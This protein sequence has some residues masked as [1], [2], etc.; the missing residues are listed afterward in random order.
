MVSGR[1]WCIWLDG[2]CSQTSLC[3][4]RSQ[5]GLHVSQE[6][7]LSCSAS[8]PERCSYVLSWLMQRHHHNKALTFEGTHWLGFVAD[9]FVVWFE[10]PCCG[11]PA[12]SCIRHL[13]RTCS[14][15]S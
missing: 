5:A 12:V 3:P 9:A 15:P 2:S 1:R 14:I 8:S 11:R 6:R 13:A 10:Q 7:P 4:E